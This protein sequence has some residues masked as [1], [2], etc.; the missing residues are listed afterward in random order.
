MISRRMFLKAAVIGSAFF[1]LGIKTAFA[2]K[3]TERRLKLFNI[4]TDEKLDITYFSNGVYDPT[5]IRKINYFMRCHYTN[6]VK[7]IDT[8]VVNLLT[9]IKDSFGG[10]RELRI[11]SG[12]RSPQYNEY[13]RS[14]G[15]HV[16]RHSLHMQGLAI[17]FAVDGIDIHRTAVMAKS[18]RAGGVGTYPDFVHIDVGRVRY[19]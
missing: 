10:G 5:A 7:A 19:W 3:K 16:A 2:S 11:I 9:D 17:D 14:I 6:D 18:F 12:Y 4:H 8:G 15:R 1:P 13:L